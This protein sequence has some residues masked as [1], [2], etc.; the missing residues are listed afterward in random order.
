MAFTLFPAEIPAPRRRTTARPALELKD[1]QA[2]ER[3]FAFVVDRNVAAATLVDAAAGADKALIDD[4]RVFDEYVGSIL[5]ED[6]KSLAI[7]VRL[8]PAETTLTETEIEAVSKT[9]VEKVERATGGILR[10]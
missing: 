4:V 8:Q 5:G 3:D 10:G 6:K 2:V 1:L 9:I 7:T